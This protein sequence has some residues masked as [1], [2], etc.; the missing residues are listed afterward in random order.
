RNILSDTVA[1]NALNKFES[2]LLKYF[3]DAPN[4]LDDE[5]LEMLRDIHDFIND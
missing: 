2:N 1:K 4:V 3:E 5:E